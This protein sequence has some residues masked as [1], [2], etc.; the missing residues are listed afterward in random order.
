M[1]TTAFSN[2]YSRELDVG[3]LARLILQDA[4]NSSEDHLSDAQRVWIRTD[5]RCSS[6]GVGGAQIVRATK[7]VGAR[8]GTR[9]A[10]FRFIGDDAMDA[11]HR[12]CEFHQ[13]DGRERQPESLIDFGSAKTIE[14][15]LIGQLV[16]QGI[17]Q[18]I[19]DQAAIR[20]MRQYF[21]DV[22]AANRFTVAIDPNAVDWL[23]A[24][25][26]HPSYQRWVFH[27]VQARLRGFDWKQATRQAFTEQFWPL[28]EHMSGRR[29]GDD[30]RRTKDLV[31]RYAGQEVFNPA[32]LKSSYELTLQLATFIGRNSGL[33]FRRSKP[34]EYWWKGAPPALLALCALILYVSDWQLNAAIGKFAQILVAPEPSDPLLG[35]VVGLNPFHDYAAWQMVV[36][37]QE[38]AEQPMGVRLY[39]AELVRIE[40][41][42][43]EAYRVWTDG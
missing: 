38:I 20:G 8:G 30:K 15:R 1:P 9:Q 28:F 35:N 19:F 13:A 24:L 3:Q 21:F 33:D 5:V 10:H 29:L 39:E 36:L 2:Y 40:T 32:A 12:F 26:C 6:C 23:S 37:A 4:P 11:H 22:R 25:W 16:C 41:E 14:T 31:A 34:D 18:G 7:P 27:P 42:L 43:R 17:E